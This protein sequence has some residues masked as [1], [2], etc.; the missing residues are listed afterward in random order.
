MKRGI[1]C[2]LALLLLLTGCS[3]GVLQ[4]DQ[5]TFINESEQVPVQNTTLGNETTEPATQPPTE[6]AS[7]IPEET[8][9]IEGTWENGSITVVALDDATLR[10]QIVDDRPE[11]EYENL[12]TPWNLRIEFGEPVYKENKLRLAPYVIGLQSAAYVCLETIEYEHGNLPPH[13]GESLKTLWLGKSV[14]SGDDAPPYDPLVYADLEIERSGNTYTAIISLPE[15]F[16]V[17]AIDGPAQVYVTLCDTNFW[18]EMAVN[19]Q[20]FLVASH[21]FGSAEVPPETPDGTV[22]IEGARENCEITVIALDDATLWVQITDFRLDQKYEDLGTPWQLSLSF[23]ETLKNE[24][25]GRKVYESPYQI[26]LKSPAHAGLEAVEYALGN[27]PSHYTEEYLNPLWFGKVASFL[28]DGYLFE[29]SGYADLDVQR[30][31]NVYTVIISLPEWFDVSAIDDLS[32]V[33]ISLYDTDYWHELGVNGTP[34]IAASYF[35]SP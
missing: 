34:Y 14:L 17:S 18:H 29:P 9:L 25:D 15:W 21:S 2:L 35:F 3:S 31:S 27:L 4:G 20:A 12:G 7:G 11:D 22:L 6:A 30:T 8:V 32:Y 10:V 13:Y 24:I 28:G 23:G 33:E 1:L 16:D 5:D 19:G 26:E